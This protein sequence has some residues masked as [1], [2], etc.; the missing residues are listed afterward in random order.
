MSA[1]FGQRR[2][3]SIAVLDR[4]GGTREGMLRHTAWFAVSRRDFLLYSRV[5]SDEA[6][7]SR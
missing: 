3:T 7:G 6:I 1:A 2:W 5:R 4:R